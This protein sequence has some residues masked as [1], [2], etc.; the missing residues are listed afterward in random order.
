MKM[1]IAANIESPEVVEEINKLIKS[2]VKPDEIDYDEIVFQANL[3][4]AKEYVMADK[5]GS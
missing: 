4:K 3:K 5:G 2:G 1:G